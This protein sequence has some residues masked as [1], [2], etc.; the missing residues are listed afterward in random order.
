MESKEAQWIQLLCWFKKKK[1]ITKILKIIIKDITFLQGE[2]PLLPQSKAVFSTSLARKISTQALFRAEAPLDG[3]APH[4]YP[5]TEYSVSS[6]RS[7]FKIHNLVP[8]LH[9][10]PFL[11]CI[12]KQSLAKFIFSSSDFEIV[13]LSLGLRDQSQ[14]TPNQSGAALS[15]KERISS[16]HTN[17][18]I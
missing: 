12:M 4:P 10:Q 7:V 17:K 13:L 6:P 9:P 14:T 16:V 8:E 3:Q 15:A 2:P 5:V 18:P 11:F 1:L